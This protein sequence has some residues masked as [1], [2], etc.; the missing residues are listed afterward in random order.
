MSAFSELQST[1]TSLPIPLGCLLDVL[2]IFVPFEHVRPFRAPCCGLFQASAGYL[3]PFACAVS[4]TLPI[5]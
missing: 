1:L 4:R 2:L 3:N 5:E